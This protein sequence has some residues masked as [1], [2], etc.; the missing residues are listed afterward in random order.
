MYEIH[1]KLKDDLEN[2]DLW[3]EIINQWIQNNK[4]YLEENDFKDAAYW[5]NEMANISCLVGAIWKIGGVAISEYSVDKKGKTDLSNRADLYFSKNKVRYIIEAKYIRNQNI[6][7]TSVMDMARKECNNI[8]ENEC[9]KMGMVFVS[10]NENQSI[11]FDDF[12]YDIN[13][14]FKINGNKKPDYEGKVY[15]TVYLFGKY[16]ALEK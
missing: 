12:D 14:M 2:A 4:D 3:L 11:T 15:N 7:I 9:K 5:H 1:I 13:V 8:Q 10:P 16:I 6:N